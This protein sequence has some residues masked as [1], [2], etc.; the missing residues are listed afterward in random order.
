M[1]ELQEYQ[2]VL[3]EQKLLALQEQN[4]D[5]NLTTALE[6]QLE[7]KDVKL[8]ASIK[9]RDKLERELSSVKSEIA[10]LRR[11]LELERQ[12]RKDLET[13][14]LDLIKGAKRKWEAAE[15]DKIARLNQ[16]IEAQ[17]VRITELCTSNND[18]SS[19]LQ[20]TQC[21]LETA[22][23]EL[24]KLKNLQVQYKESLAKTRELRRQSVQGVE[25]KLEEIANRA[26][27]Q[28]AEVR[29]KLEMEIAKNT[30]LE[31][32]LRN[33]RDSHHCQLSRINVALELS[34]S[35]LRDCQE[36]LRS[37]QAM[38]PAR[39]QEI[40][41]LRKQ[42]K[43]R[44]KQMES[45]GS[46]ERV[47]NNLKDEIA[48]LKLENDQMKTQLETAKSDLNDTLKNLQKSESIASKLEQTAQVKDELQQKLE[49]SQEK[50]NEQLRKMDTLE[51]LLQRLQQSVAKLESENDCLRRSTNKSLPSTSRSST[52]QKES[53]KV[54]LLEQQLE[55]LEK[56][57]QTA[58]ENAT[59][60]REAARQAQRSLWKKEKE[61]S[62]ANLDKRIALREVKTAEE[63]IKNLEEEKKRL[64]DLLDKKCKEEEEKA[65]KLLSEL[66]SAKS[67]L[68]Q[69]DRESSRN[70]LQADSAQR[71][72]TQTNKQVEELQSSSAALRRE[73]DAARK[74]ARTNQDRVD[75]LNAEN[76]RLTMAI[77]KHNEEKSELESK[78]EKLEQEANGYKINIDLLKETCTVLEE[79]LTDYEKLTSDHETRENT[80]IQDKMRLQKELENIEQKLREAKIAQNEEKTKRLVAERSM[81]R[82]VSETQDLESERNSLVAQRDQYK[83]LAQDLNKQVAQLTSQCGEFECDIAELQRAVDTARGEAMVVKEECSQHLTHLHEMKDIN[84]DLVADLQASI[85][86][87]Q[88]LRMRITELEN[89]LEEMRQFYQE[90][91][92]KSEGTRQQQTKLIDYLQLKLEE[93]SKKKK[94][95]CEKIFKSKQ[96]ENIPPTGMGMPVGYRELENQLARERAKVKALTEQLL[97]YKTAAATSAPVSPT[98]RSPEFKKSAQQSNDQSEDTLARQMSLQR[99][100][101]NIPHRYNIELSMRAGK[102]A[103]CLEPIQFGKRSAICSECQIMTHLKCSLLTPANCGLPGGFAKHLEEKSWKNSAESISTLSGSV[104]TLTIDEPDHTELDS[105]NPRK[106]ES[107]TMESWVKIPGRGKASWDRK[108][109][110]LEDSTLY[111]Y[112]HEPTPG[113]GPINR[114]ELSDKSGFT[115]CEDILQADV[116]GTA[117]SDL[118]FILRVESN[119]SNTC[120]PTSRLDIMALSQI[121]KKGWLNAIKSIAYRNG[122]KEVAKSSML[123]TILKLEKNRLDLNCIVEVENENVLLVGA[124]EGLYSYRPSHSKVLTAIRGVKKVHQLTLHSHLNL[125]LM[126]A[127]EDRQ[128]VSCDLRQLKSNALAAECSRPAITT[129]KVLTGTESCHLY[130]L[131][132]DMLCAATASYVMLLKWHS[133]EDVGEFIAMKEIETQEPCSCAIF[134]KDNLI[135]GCQKFFQIDTKNYTVDDFPEDDDSSVK[136]ALAGVAK[137]GIFPVAVLN[138]SSSPQSTELLLCYNEF[139][140]FVNEFGQRTRCID[141]TWSHLPFAFA[142]RKPYLFVVH[143]SSVEV[144]KL[145]PEA[146]RSSTKVPEKT[147]IELNNPRYLGFAGM[148]SIYVA[149]TNATLDILKI[150]GAAS[151]LSRRSTSISSLD[152]LCN[153]DDDSSE[154]SFTPSL[155]DALDNPGKRVHFANLSNQT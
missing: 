28:L 75:T 93:S 65:K 136:A 78:L 36:Q 18:M 146:F 133:N 115:I 92:L 105:G 60:E 51:E 84:Q 44:S 137:V 151:I 64:R 40:E 48:K 50:E 114:I 147:L 11:T 148:K 141:P 88:E 119:T 2:L 99:I 42:L 35:E 34:Q 74:Q 149:V 27:N 89:I 138:V 120:W 76:K 77:S 66:E 47:V 46:Y 111:I 97:A 63:K 67:S 109:L 86:Q 19:R 127:G 124:E 38:I 58:R 144:I 91:E 25:N 106:N 14:A 62:D 59:T 30:E 53:E 103:A 108:Y 41:T 96:K 153:N 21:E 85:D 139:G 150:D 8:E 122:T 15:K 37:T 69:F 80:L 10:T 94:T 154:F 52:N 3:R 117:K 134:T 98:L 82:L 126:I 100:R 112:E 142:F 23:A 29:M 110:R 1:K 70:K 57:L 56:Q 22:K 43:E 5:A 116:P 45:I 104:Q 123:Q 95:V 90:H 121:D 102:C 131:E 12:E 20:R 81:E 128:L 73:L 33:E 113:M 31:S 87:G 152:S 17:T 129:T 132:G 61:L 130:Q 55:R 143:F 79:Q 32:Q 140:V 107:V 135:V 26:H 13:T 118:P 49:E 4:N 24:H 6:L 125:A 145:S 71:A 155:L 39:D 7:E 16:H 101:H 68:A 83:K 54:A 9:E 72:L